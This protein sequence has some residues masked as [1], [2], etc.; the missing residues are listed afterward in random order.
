MTFQAQIKLE[1]ETA[2]IYWGCHWRVT[3]F[4]IYIYKKK[5]SKYSFLFKL[6]IKEEYHEMV[7]E[8]IRVLMTS[9][10]LDQ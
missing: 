10:T 5:T 9:V 7:V 4:I 3:K 8:V 1:I 6:I 2:L